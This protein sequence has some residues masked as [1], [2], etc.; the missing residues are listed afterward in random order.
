MGILAVLQ[1]VKSRT[2]RSSGV[3]LFLE[4]IETLC[5]VTRLHRLRPRRCPGIHSA[6]A[7]QHA[8]EGLLHLSAFAALVPSLSSRRL[9]A[10]ERSGM[11]VNAS[12]TVYQLINNGSHV[13]P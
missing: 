6:N 13:G 7:R 11:V 1:G 9:F 3:V 10:G 2:P 4:N 8:V 12:R 5:L